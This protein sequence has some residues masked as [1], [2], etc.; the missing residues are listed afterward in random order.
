VHQR[1]SSSLGKEGWRRTNERGLSGNAE[2]W[3]V[4]LC[5]DRSP[6]TYTGKDRCEFLP[7]KEDEGAMLDARDS[8]L[9]K[10]HSSVKVGGT[11]IGRLA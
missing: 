6:P 1:K 11:L 5:S 9:V 7:K 10:L 4:E 2:I 3:Y 8:I